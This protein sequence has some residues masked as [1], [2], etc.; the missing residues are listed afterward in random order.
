MY[1]RAA[2][3]DAHT[4]DQIDRTGAGF[5][6]CWIQAGLDRD[7][8]QKVGRGVAGEVT[9]YA[10]PTSRLSWKRSASIRLAGGK[11]IHDSGRRTT[12]G[13]ISVAQLA[14]ILSVSTPN[15]LVCWTFPFDDLQP[16]HAPKNE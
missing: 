4:P 14:V 1:S 15:P 16:A 6:N 8:Q 3:A 10:W 9:E 7:R 11:D 2:A 5:H 13:P 12:C